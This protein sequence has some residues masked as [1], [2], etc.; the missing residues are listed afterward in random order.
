MHARIYH[1]DLLDEDPMKTS[2]STSLTDKLR[3]E[4]VRACMGLQL[5]AVSQV[6]LS[7]APT[8]PL[9]LPHPT[10][11]STPPLTSCNIPHTHS[12]KK[13]SRDM[14]R[15]QNTSQSFDLSQEAFKRFESVSAPL[16]EDE[17]EGMYLDHIKG[18]YLDHIK[19]TGLQY[20]TLLT[21]TLPHS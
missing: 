10:A 2:S 3:G 20:E 17:D 7:T 1:Q 9:P 19:G 13:M 15:R 18:M 14:L 4:S 21:S 16:E 6:V 5:Y 12:E 11:P 8:S